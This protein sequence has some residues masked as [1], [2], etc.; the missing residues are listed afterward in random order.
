MEFIAYVFDENKLGKG[1][2]A[3]LD[4]V[5]QEDVEIVENVQKGIRSRYYTHGRYS[6][7][8]EQGTHQEKGGAERR[9]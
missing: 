2:G 3:S 5:E 7:T 8:K 6:A 4:K 9:V 1:A